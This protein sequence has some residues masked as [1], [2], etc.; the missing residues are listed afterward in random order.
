MIDSRLKSAPDC[1][2]ISTLVLTKVN[3]YVTNQEAKYIC[4]TIKDQH[5]Q[6]INLT[7]Y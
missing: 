1:I 3:E 6:E 7:N 5:I 2:R 4:S